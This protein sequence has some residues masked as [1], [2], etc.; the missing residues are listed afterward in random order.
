MP[1]ISVV[2]DAVTIVYDDGVD[3]IS[4][5]DVLA[6]PT[7]ETDTSKRLA[8][9]GSGGVEFV[10][11]GGG[12]GFDSDQTVATTDATPTVIDTYATL[13][14]SKGVTLDCYVEGYNVAGVLVASHIVKGTFTRDGA[15][16][17]SEADVNHLHT[18]QADPTWGLPDFNVAA[19][20]IEIRVTGKA[21]TVI[22]WR[23]RRFTAEV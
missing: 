12:G 11:G 17:V 4:V 13:A 21:A 7:V 20:S 1:D 22:N 23:M 14:N 16:V 10:A 2:V 5:P 15:G 6:L 8:P 18:Y 9:D 19:Q 3:K